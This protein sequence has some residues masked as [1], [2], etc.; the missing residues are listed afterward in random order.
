MILGLPGMG[1][2]TSLIN[3]CVQLVRQGI[4]PIV[5]SYHQDIDEKLA[6][7]LA[8]PPLTVKYAGLGFNP[9]EVVGDGP[10]AHLDNAGMLRD[11]F[12]AIFPDLG[13]VQLGRL[14]KAL[15]QSYLDRGWG[16]GQRGE[17]P[18]F[19]AFL[20]LLRADPKPDKGL[21]TRLDELEDY[22]LFAAGSGTPTLLHEQ[23][24]AL[25]EIHGTQN[26]H[27]QCA[28]ATFVL[29]NLY[30]GM[31]QRGPQPR[32]THAVVFDEAHKAARLKLLASMAKE[33]RKYGI[34]FVVASQEAKDFDESLVNA[35]ANYL[36][37]RLNEADARLM[38]KSFAASDQVKQVTDRIKQMPKYQAMYYGEG[39]RAATRVRLLAEPPQP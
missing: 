22:G 28:F 36:A 21:L 38:A 26:E 7:R 30:Q 20:A 11:I 6:E 1:K 17:T 35:I 37:L 33:C 24:P 2:T 3:I 16:P 18:D 23:R 34:A 27:L 14:R 32:I 15:M 19:D 25:I 31:F 29:Y 13:D 5:F 12:S 9:M 4:A 10:L 8:E 39:L